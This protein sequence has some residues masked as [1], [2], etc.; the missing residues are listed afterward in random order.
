M[1]VTNAAQVV[2]AMFVEVIKLRLIDTYQKTQ[3]RFTEKQRATKAEV[4]TKKV[5]HKALTEALLETPT[6][7]AERKCNVDMAA[8]EEADLPAVFTLAIK[9]VVSAH[10]PCIILARRP[11]RSDMAITYLLRAD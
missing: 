5:E 6:A 10:T 2:Q 3:Q 1:G 11:Y 9:H 4:A 8:L 7:A